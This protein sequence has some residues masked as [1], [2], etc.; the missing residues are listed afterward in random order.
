MSKWQ[1]PA[2]LDTVPRSY[3]FGFSIGKTTKSPN[4]CP[5]EKWRPLRYWSSHTLH[6]PPEKEPPC[7]TSP[8]LGDLN[9]TPWSPFFTDLLRDGQLHDGR[10]GFGILPTWEKLAGMVRI[11]IDHVLHSEGVAITDLRVLP[12]N[13]SDHRPIVFEA[14]IGN[15]TPAAPRPLAR[16]SLWRERIRN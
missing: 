7:P 13:G 2:R 3:D 14:R 12:G 15:E 6:R 8:H 9:I 1:T 11:P 4:R 16:A 10:R 5:G